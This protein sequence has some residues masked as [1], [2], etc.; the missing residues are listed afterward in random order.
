MHVVSANCRD[1][2]RIPETNILASNDIE[3]KINCRL[4]ETKGLSCHLLCRWLDACMHDIC[5]VHYVHLHLGN[6]L[7]KYWQWGWMWWPSLK[8]TRS[9]LYSLYPW[10]Y[11]CFKWVWINILMLLGNFFETLIQIWRQ[12][13]LLLSYHLEQKEQD[14]VMR[15]LPTCLSLCLLYAQHIHTRV[16]GWLTMVY[17]GLEIFRWSY[18]IVCHY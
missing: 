18:G 1:R 8:N 6:P 17:Q 12:V 7:F 9:A 2:G 4:E 5:G 11:S 15:T 14:W 3:S 10:Y 16:I 13:T